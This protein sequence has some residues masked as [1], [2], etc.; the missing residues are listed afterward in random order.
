VRL[1]YPA[2]LIYETS[3]RIF[4]AHVS[5][6]DWPAPTVA[7]LTL[8]LDAPEDFTF[9]SGQY[10]RIRVPGT[11]EW[12]SYS[13]A[14]TPRDLPRLDFLVRL[15]GGGAMSEY[16]RMRCRVGDVIEIEGPMGAFILH[17]SRAP[18]IF[19]AGGTGLAPIISMLDEIRR[20]SSPRPKMLLS[21]GC[22]S[23]RQFFYR[24]EIE[25]RGW[26]MPEL[27][28]ILSADQVDD[29]DSGLVCGT[30]VA[31][32]GEARIADPDTSAYLCGPPPMIAAARRRLAELGVRADRIYAEQF[33][34]SS[35]G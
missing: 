30:P 34:S 25:L 9:R 11:E 32:L 2:S 26:W 16:L 27:R 24:D 19:I 20:R 35:I 10:V 28:M 6:L 4:A 3:R 22:A 29:P 17:P 33:V 23:E 18:H 14:S 15:I 21:F 1:H 13:M 8:E 5:S 12:R 7:K 31:A